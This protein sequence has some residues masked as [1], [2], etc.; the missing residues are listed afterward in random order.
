M[1]VIR[2]DW[3]WKSLQLHITAIERRGELWDQHR[4]LRQTNEYVSRRI[5]DE[6]DDDGDVQYTVEDDNVGYDGATDEVE[7]TDLEGAITSDELS[8]DEE[9][10][11]SDM[12][13]EEYKDVNNNG[14]FLLIEIL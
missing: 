1:R 2:P 7:T 9:R 12:E 3:D 14:K 4:N 13:V 11:I 5:Y 10:D 6:L 8:G